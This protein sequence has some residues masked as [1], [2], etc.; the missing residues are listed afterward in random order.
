MDI[1]PAVVLGAFH[2][3][4]KDGECPGVSTA[5]FDN[6]GG[7]HGSPNAFGIE[8]SG[9]GCQVAVRAKGPT[10]GLKSFDGCAGNL[11]VETTLGCRDLSQGCHSVF[12]R[13]WIGKGGPIQWPPK[14][15]D[16][17][18]PDFFL[19]GY[20]KNIVYQSPIRDAE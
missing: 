3:V 11:C 15:P 12:P 6:Y 17:A 7:D 14:S 18:P 4:Q 16:I 5:T 8:N 19:W 20:M 1:A 9:H 10:H 13:R 2:M